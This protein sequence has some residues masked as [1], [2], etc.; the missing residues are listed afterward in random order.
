MFTAVQVLTDRRGR[1]VGRYELGMSAD[2]EKTFGIEGGSFNITGWGGWPDTEGIDE[3]SVGSA[4]GINS[5]AYGNRTLDIVEFFYEGP[6]F[7]DNWTI[8]V[9][10]MDFTGILMRANMQ[11]TSAASL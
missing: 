3:S 7:S 6:L 9:G 11:M 2:L 1:H 8:S 5:L 10:K 4:W